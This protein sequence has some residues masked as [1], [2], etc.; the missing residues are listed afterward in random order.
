M[1]F[2]KNKKNVWKTLQEKV[3]TFFNLEFGYIIPE[4]QDFNNYLTL[5]FFQ[6]GTK[7]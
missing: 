7:L 6:V 3:R 5:V 4:V 2:D 1:F